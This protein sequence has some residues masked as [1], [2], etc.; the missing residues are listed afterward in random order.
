[1]QI[2]GI[3]LMGTICIGYVIVATHTW[4][5]PKW[6]CLPRIAASYEV[7][8][9]THLVMAVAVVVLLVLHPLP[10]PAIN[11][12]PNRSTTWAYMAAGVAMYALERILR[13]LK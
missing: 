3:V 4:P 13:V 10:G 9:F 1:M 12:Q 7:F 8:Y 5:L 11:P 2:T 6:L